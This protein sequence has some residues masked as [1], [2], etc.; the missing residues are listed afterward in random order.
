MYCYKLLGAPKALSKIPFSCSI[1]SFWN[2]PPTLPQN[3]TCYISTAS[4]TSI[5]NTNSGLSRVNKTNRTPTFSL[6]QARRCYSDIPARKDNDPAVKSSP[7]M[8]VEIYFGNLGLK[9]K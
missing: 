4:V 2:S 1:C 6:K 9:V 3:M 7:G 8:Y 5:S